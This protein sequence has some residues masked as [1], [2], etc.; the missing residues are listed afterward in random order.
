[1][2]GSTITIFLVFLYF[3]P[4]LVGAKKR[5]AAAIF[6]LNLLLGWTFIGWVVAMVWALTYEPEIKKDEI[7]FSEEKTSK[8]IHSAEK[9]EQFCDDKKWL[10]IFL[11]VAL[12]IFILPRS[13]SPERNDAEAVKYDE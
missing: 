1:M 8:V 9:L 13:C 10:I 12:M 11:V 2:D 7:K 5:N 4:T 6:V 3:L